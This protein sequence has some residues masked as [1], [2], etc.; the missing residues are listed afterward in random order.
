MGSLVLMAANG[1][2]GLVIPDPRK[3]RWM[4]VRQEGDER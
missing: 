2:F 4:V 1:R 3:V